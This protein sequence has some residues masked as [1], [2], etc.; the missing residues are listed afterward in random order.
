[1]DDKYRAAFL[2]HALGDTI[3]YKN[4]EW[5]FNKNYQGN[6]SFTVTRELLYEFIELGGINDIDLNGWN[7]S[8]DT[9]LHLVMGEVLSNTKGKPLEN[10]IKELIKEL[11]DKDTIE[12]LKG[13]D[14]G[15]AT[16]MA[17]KR[18]KDGEDYT[19]HKYD[20]NEGGSGAAMRN[21]VIGMAFYGKENRQKLIEVALET[22]R[23]THN[24]S[25]GYLGGLTSALFG[26]YAVEGVPL[27]KWPF[28]LIKLLESDVTDNYF[29][30]T[31]GLAEHQRDKE[32]FIEKWKKY[33]EDRFD[34]NK[35]F[36]Y[37]KSF[38]NVVFRTKYYYD[39]FAYDEK[40]VH[41]GAGGD[42][43][44]IIA[45]DALLDAGKS[46]EKLV[47]YSMIHM[48]DS[49]TTG[50]IAG[51]LYGLMYGLENV[52]KNNLKYLEEKDMI[53]NI[54]NKIIKAYLPQKL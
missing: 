22:S 27:H 36:V 48:G 23:V 30:K 47:I 37:N 2:L 32:I 50:S 18:L 14:P 11:T 34:E 24:S 16:M 4:G 26:A 40:I 9:I 21:I 43:S 33:T 45:Y 46:W 8:D 51:G 52:P 20:F 17:I 54:A 42:D 44:V 38:R 6:F 13:R 41:P 3:G 15:E 31:R 1:M 5:E 7:I 35:K 28:K 25:T 39:N 12:S 10:I 29:K 53:L 19:K 49:D